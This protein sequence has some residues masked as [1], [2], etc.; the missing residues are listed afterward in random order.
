M[1]QQ[2]SKGIAIAC[3]LVS[4]L[5]HV[6]IISSIIFLLLAPDRFVKANA[7]QCLGMTLIYHIVITIITLV[8]FGLGGILFI[9]PTILAILGAIKAARE[10]FSNRLYQDR[11]SR[12]LFE[13]SC[14]TQVP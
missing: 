13:H 3:W 8:T 9:V 14:P 10:R 7:A 5:P 11:L 12:A 6:G 1:A 2:E 4:L